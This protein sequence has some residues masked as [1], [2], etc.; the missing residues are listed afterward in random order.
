MTKTKKKIQWLLQ[1]ANVFFSFPNI[2]IQM[3]ISPRIT[4]FTTS[5][6]VSNA[7][8]Y[9]CKSLHFVKHSRYKTKFSLNIPLVLISVFDAMHF[10]NV[11]K[12]STKFLIWLKGFCIGKY[13]ME[14]TLGM[15]RTN[16]PKWTLPTRGFRLPIYFLWL[17]VGSKR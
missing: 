2:A 8:C 15:H 5:T 4:I 11:I 7:N 17:R 14:E 13:I 1:K 3:N 6:N 16:T 10:I 12:L 9:K